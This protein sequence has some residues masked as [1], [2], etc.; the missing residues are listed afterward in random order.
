[1]S[2]IR[3][4]V[5]I[6][7]GIAGPVA[8]L[9]LRKAGL[10]ATVFEAYDSSADD[11]GGTLAVAANGLA[12]LELVGAA[13][14]VRAVAQP[15]DRQVMS[16]G[17]RTITLPGVAAPHVIRR[18]DLHRILRDRAG[19]IAGKRLVS[20]TE[21]DGQVTAAFADGT[22]ATGDILIGADGVRSTV[23]RLIDPHA[24]GPRYTGMIA[25]EGHSTAEVDVA[26]GTITFAF[27]RRAY[28]LYWPAPG[29]GTTFGLNVP[30]PAGFT[31]DD[32]PGLLR[33]V[34]GDDS[35]GAELIAHADQLQVTG[36]LH[37]MPPVPRWHRGR[38]VLTGDAVHA[39]S[40]SSGQGAS[41]AIES[42]IVLARCLRDEADVEKAFRTYES[43]RRPRVEAIAAQAA[44]VN[45]AKV[46]GPVARALLPYV[47]PV[48][49]RLF[50]GPDKVLRYRID[51]AEPVR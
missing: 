45:H 31:T 8:A 5:V 35:P 7:G 26:P 50:G 15:A 20:A 10:E 28:Y 19:V 29:G 49:F 37:I 34:Y 24:P 13:D 51:W 43:L 4:A 1:M 23:R 6:G 3:T 25:V 30:R 32:W 9:A 18:G 40:N 17:G 22:T 11:V 47:M 42:A 33:E 2:A 39:P 21:H 41:L 48:F 46:P 36:P 27:G 38:L 12:A 14:A 44:K 16:V